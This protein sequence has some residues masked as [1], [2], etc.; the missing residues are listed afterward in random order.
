[1]F[2]QFYASLI[3][4]IL[5]LFQQFFCSLLLFF[6]V[7]TVSVSLSSNYEANY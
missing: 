5:L 4:K 7:G 1:M 6:F 3:E 2:D